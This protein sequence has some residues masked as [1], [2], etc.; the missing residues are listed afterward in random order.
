MLKATVFIRGNAKKQSNQRC[1]Q[2]DELQPCFLVFS[3]LKNSIT[4][5]KLKF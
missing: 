4:A 2:I 5:S 1:W 3:R